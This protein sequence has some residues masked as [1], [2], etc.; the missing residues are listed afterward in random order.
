M[1][2]SAVRL[3][4]YT[5]RCCFLDWDALSSNVKAHGRAHELC[6]AS[7]SLSL[8]QNRHIGLRYEATAKTKL[9]GFSDSDW[10]VRHSTSGYTFH[11][12]SA[13]ISWLS[14][15]Q[16]SVALSSCEAE[17]MAGSVAA[18]E[19]IYLSNFLRELGIDSDGPTSLYLA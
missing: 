3:C 2:G 8:S 12:G 10:A 17:I 18:T 9:E 16:P 13:T 1:R 11:H 19:A 15:K 6:L 4:E 7:A 14:K 5:S